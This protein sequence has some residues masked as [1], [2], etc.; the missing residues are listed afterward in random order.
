MKLTQYNIVINTSGRGTE[1]IT[2]RMNQM[3][4]DL[5]VSSGL[6][7]LFI[8]H[9]SASLLICENYDSQVRKDLENFLQRLVPDG[10]PL[11]KHTE[12]GKD[13]MPAH[14]RTILTETSLSVP[15]SNGKL[16]LGTYQGIFLYEHRFAAQKR[17]ILMTI[18]A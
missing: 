13:D 5:N 11:F 14:I 1:E 10:D 2:P 12:E 18:I 17:H 8:R 7:H 6:C 3:I 15:I 9:T 16:A 4:T